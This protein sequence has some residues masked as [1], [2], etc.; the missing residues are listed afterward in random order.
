MLAGV[1][2]AA[3]VPGAVVGVAVTDVPVV[4]AAV[5][6]AGVVATAVTG[7][8]EL[9]PLWSSLGTSKARTATSTTE[10]PIATFFIFLSFAARTSSARFCLRF[11]SPSARARGRRRAARSG[12][13]GRRGRRR[14]GAGAGGGAVV[15]ATDCGTNSLI[16]TVAETCGHP[17]APSAR[18]TLLTS[19]RRPAVKSLPLHAHEVAHA[20]QEGEQVVV[21]AGELG[22][23]RLRGEGIHRGG[24]RRRARAL[25]RDLVEPDPDPARGCSVRGSRQA[26]RGCSAWPARG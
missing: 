10:S 4:G 14:G 9:P 7:W 13:R 26:C 17:A 11:M 18:A 22:L 5:A 24:R 6:P 1:R 21:A 25:G 2:A 20:L 8:A 15:A 16:V 19:N 12:R 23:D 3:A